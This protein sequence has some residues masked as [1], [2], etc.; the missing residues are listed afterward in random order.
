MSK[1]LLGKK[2]TQRDFINE[3]YNEFSNIREEKENKILDNN[4]KL[5]FKK[6]IT[7]KL[8]EYEIQDS[9]VINVNNNKNIENKNK[10]FLF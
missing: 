3:E 5:P 2:R 1:N 4:I 9:N 8:T 10:L 6:I 7:E